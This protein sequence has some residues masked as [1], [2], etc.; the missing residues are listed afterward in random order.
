MTFRSWGKRAAIWATM[1]RF[2]GLTFVRQFFYFFEQKL[3]QKRFNFSSHPSLLERYPAASP[4]LS[5]ANFEHYL[6]PNCVLSFIDRVPYFLSLLKD[7]FSCIMQ[8]WQLLLFLDTLSPFLSQTLP[9]LTIRPMIFAFS[10]FL[11]SWVWHFT[12][13]RLVNLT[14]S[15]W[16]KIG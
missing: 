8:I 3:L 10:A 16:L 6:M 15:I 13:A 7:P 2:K 12:T 1:L 14:K 11:R 4:P 5:K 9:T